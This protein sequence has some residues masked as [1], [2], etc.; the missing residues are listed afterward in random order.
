M[1]CACVCVLHCMCACG[2]YMCVWCVG[3]WCV[4]V[5]VCAHEDRVRESLKSVEYLSCGFYSKDQIHSK[6]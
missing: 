1:M 2:V 3:M 6:Y 5:C 4:C